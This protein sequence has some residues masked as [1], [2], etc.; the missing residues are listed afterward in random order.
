MALPLRPPP[1]HQW[2]AFTLLHRWSE[3]NGLRP[4]E[5]SPLP[6]GNTMLTFFSATQAQVW[7]SFFVTSATA[8]VPAGCG[9]AVPA[10]LVHEDAMLQAAA[11]PG[12]FAADAAAAGGGGG[13]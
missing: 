7:R 8:A 5:A 1:Q 12:A 4:P 9:P 3:A 13:A 11:M 10:P 2:A 6:D